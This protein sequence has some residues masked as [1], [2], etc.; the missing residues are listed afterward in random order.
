MRDILFRGKNVNNGEWVYG[1]LYIGDDKNKHLILAGRENYR[2]SHEVIPETI[3]QFTGL[4]D[5][6]GEHIFEGDVIRAHY[7]NNFDYI[8]S[9]VFHNGMFCG[10]YTPNYKFRRYTVLADGE[11]NLPFYTEWYMKWCEVVGNVHDNPR[12]IKTNEDE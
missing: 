4:M 10:L 5:R 2:I 9:V 7:N 8:E 1:N 11:V 12:L 6:N 3:G